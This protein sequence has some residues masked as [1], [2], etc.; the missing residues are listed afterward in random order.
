M[1]DGVCYATYSAAD[2]VCG[3]LKHDDHWHRT[4]VEA[5]NIQSG[6]Q[7]PSLFALV[8]LFEIPDQP[9]Q[10]FEEFFEQLSEDFTNEHSEN[11]SKPFLSNEIRNATLHDTNR[12]LLLRNKQLSGFLN[13]PIPH[14]DVYDTDYESYHAFITDVAELNSRIET[15]NEQQ[16][17]CFEDITATL[18]NKEGK[19]FL[20]TLLVGQKRPTSLM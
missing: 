3:L 9:E 12:T 10:L 16:R 2:Q 19:L 4:L 17:Q 6:K 18:N 5:S 8:M 13:M 15:L 1:V 7:L 11:N 20:A 14:T